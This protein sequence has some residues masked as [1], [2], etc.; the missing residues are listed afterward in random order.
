FGTF[1]T[2]WYIVRSPAFRS[3]PG[4]PVL[5]RFFPSVLSV[6]LPLSASEGPVS[7]IHSRHCRTLLPLLRPGVPR[8]SF[9]LAILPFLLEGSVPETLPV[10]SLPDLRLN[11]PPSGYKGSPVIRT[12]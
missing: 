4:I 11:Q 5:Y 12:P 8:F 9:L 1:G 10:P 6:I 2:S 7:D 3:F